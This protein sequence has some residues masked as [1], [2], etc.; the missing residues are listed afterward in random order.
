MT[1]SYS[2]QYL[3][4]RIYKVL[5][6]SRKPSITGLRKL[7]E[8]TYELGQIFFSTLHTSHHWIVLLFRCVP[9]RPLKMPSQAV[10]KK[11]AQR[12]QL[13]QQQQ[14]QSQGQYQRDVE[15]QEHHASANASA[16]LNLNL[17]GALGGAFSSKSKKTTHQNP[18]GSCESVEHRAEKG[19]ANGQ[20]AGH[21]QAYA[22]GS[23][24]EGTRK[25]KAREIG[26][27]QSQS[28]GMQAKKIEGKKQVDHL[29]IE[30]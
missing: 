30:A 26:Q 21:G 5:F 19:A 4:R 23:A 2:P 18:D 28:Q 8:N 14:N 12:E 13:Q 17:F 7:R 22:Q 25:E 3:P 27:G 15:T 11:E 29:G 9:R 16:G 20:F 6:A 1:S 10:S 24:S